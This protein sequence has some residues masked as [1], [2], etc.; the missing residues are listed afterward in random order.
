MSAELEAAVQQV[1]EM[2][3]PPYADPN[4][5]R[6]YGQDLI[7]AGRKAS[8]EARNQA[9][10]QLASV[11]Q[12]TDIYY[13]GLLSICCGALVE[14]GGDPHLTITAIRERFLLAIDLAHAF[15]EACK[16]RA[17]NADIPL[18][19]IISE[20]GDIVRKGMPHSA[21]AWIALNYLSLALV[22]SLSVDSKLLQE[23]QSD[24]ELTARVHAFA[25]GYGQ[26]VNH[27]SR[28]LRVLDEDIVVLY[29]ELLKG[30]E[31]RISRVGDNAQLHTLLADV[32]IGTTDDLLPLERPD[33]GQVALAQGT[34]PSGYKQVAY[35]A[36]DMQQWMALEPDGT[37]R[38]TSDIALRNEEVPAD[39]AKLDNQRVVLLGPLMDEVAWPGRPSLNLLKPRVEVV[40]F[41]SQTDILDWIS[42]IQQ[43]K[44]DA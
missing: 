32:L 26:N 7:K 1:I 14:Q 27:L 44:R 4:A 34:A 6:P 12:E 2:A 21:N 16:A 9:L 23:V 22:S 28:L 18:L 11:V 25:G 41:L 42:K 33:E 37:L 43:A 5:F 38:P 3:T 15:V 10:Q 24:E 31:V 8:T 17:P 40:Q 36:F 13:A 35:A 29:P 39:I 20:Q 19:Q 30:Y